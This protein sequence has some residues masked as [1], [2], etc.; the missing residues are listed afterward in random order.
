[1][2]PSPIL[3][4]ALGAAFT[5]ATSVGAQSGEVLGHGAAEAAWSQFRGPE[6]GGVSSETGLLR[7]W[8]AA[9]PR[10]IWRRA[11]GDGFSGIAVVG[12]RFFTLFAEAEKEY[13]GAFSVA[14]GEEIW[15]QEIDSEV[16][17]D[18][19]G[20]GPRA[21]PTVVGEWLYA[22]SGRGNL[23]AVDSA[24]GKPRWQVDLFEEYGFFGPQW[25]LRAEPP[26][27]LQ[28]P[29]WGYSYS[30]LVEGDLLIAETGAGNGKSY[31]AFDR[32][33]G[34][35]RWNALDHPIGYGSPIAATLAGRRQIIAVADTE[36][37]SISLAG[38]VGWRL[39]WAPTIGQA[40][41]LPP[42]KIF[43]TTVP[44][45]HLEGGAMM[46]RVSEVGGKPQA[47]VVWKSQI[48]KSLWSTPI[49]YGDHIY[50]FDNAT[51][52]C[53]R[54]ADGEP[55]W[56]HRGLG[57]GSLIAADGLLFV[58]SDRGSVSLVEAD[59]ASYREVGRMK[60]TDSART[61]TPPTL[62][63]GQLYLRGGAEIVCLDVGG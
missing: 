24:S 46:V 55:T 29:S 15:R 13:V 54:A 1:M 12:E 45:A 61:W 9:G 2:S 58:Y 35:P 33:T 42:D 40:L 31:V 8:P 23:V 5:F 30:P 41:I 10:L 49:V 37:L 34:E 3:G 6:R 26:G 62:A 39:P 63:A 28:L 38:E 36:L 11:V 48:M 60:I 7:S 20:R 21:T 51:F 22:L 19:F 43:V 17:A 32:L 53:L 44:L 47:E 57:K 50:G 18:E 14:D 56:A 16:F 27:K 59:P 25:S 4:A 52:R